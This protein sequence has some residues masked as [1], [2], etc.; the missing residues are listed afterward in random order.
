[1]ITVKTYWDNLSR[2]DKWLLIKKYRFWDGLTDFSYK[3]IPD[4]LKDIIKQEIEEKQ[5]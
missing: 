5:A 1:M 3:W 2:S 4:D